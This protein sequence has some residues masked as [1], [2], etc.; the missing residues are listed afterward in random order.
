MFNAATRREFLRGLAAA[1]AACVA[2]PRSGRTHAASCSADHRPVHDEI[3]RR[4]GRFLGQTRLVVDYYRIG[5]KLAYPLPLTSLTIPDAVVPGIGNYPWG[6][7]LTWTLEERILALGWAAEWFH[8]EAARHAAAA[9]LAALAE[10][11]E[12]R[13][14]P[15]PDLSS[16]HA[17]RTL[18]TAATRWRWVDH[19]LRGRLHAACR[20]HVESVLPLTDKLHASIAT[21]QDVLGRKSPH[22]LLHNIALIGT[23]GAALTASA[24]E[25]PAASR[26]N[27]RLTALFGAVLDLRAKGFSEAVAYD[28]YVLDFIADWL[29]SLGEPQRR[30]ILAHPRLDDYLDESYMLGA[31]GAAEHVAELGDVEPREMPFHLS[32][33]AKLLRLRPS[34]TGAWLLRRCPLDW[35][36]SDALAALGQSSEE[37]SSPA[38][39]AGAM[40]AH[41][42]SVLRSGWEPDDLAV[43]VA[44]SNSPMGHVHNDSGSL[45]LGT[46]GKWLVTDPG[47]QQYAK[48]EEREFTMGPTA[49]NAP[50][51]NGTAQTLKQARRIV[52]EDIGVNQ[53][54]VTLDLTACYAASLGVKTAVRHVWLSGKNLVVVADQIQTRSP[55]RVTYHWH[56][57]RDCA[58]WVDAGLALLTLGR[59][60]LWLACT[61]TPL[62]GANLE[63]L[64]GSRGQLS[65]IATLAAAPPVVWWAFVL[66]PQRPTLAVRPDG[67]QLRVAG[68]TFEL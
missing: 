14:Y 15:A 30:P 45:V 13:Q 43:A 32:A 18:W 51:V 49:H 67:R 1:G 63:R 10:W 17:G 41:Y 34:S 40:D 24:A 61:H 20:R 35:L 27:A 59:T 28:G 11:P 5:R 9:D 8:D 65:L 7:W 53:H 31:P 50:V 60:Q 54:R 25:H 36:R 6:T 64:P 26:L 62:T 33:Q 22:A 37:Q 47:Y 39:R 55:A 48:G 68:Q 66:G 56:G 42:A 19:A 16:A 38:P 2:M 58:W 57:H 3:R 4:A 44:C 12:Y 23:V 21:R 29:S 46:Q 52:L